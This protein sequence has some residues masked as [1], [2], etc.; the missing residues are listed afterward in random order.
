[1][2]L[3]DKSKE[4]IFGRGDLVV[5]TIFVGTQGEAPEFL[6]WRQRKQYKPKHKS[7]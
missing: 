6:D 1:M 4:I 5:D 2:D 7:W 3:D